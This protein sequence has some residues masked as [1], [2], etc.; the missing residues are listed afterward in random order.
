MGQESVGTKLK[1]KSKKLKAKSKKL[2][3]GEIKD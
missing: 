3:L 2:Q 1:A